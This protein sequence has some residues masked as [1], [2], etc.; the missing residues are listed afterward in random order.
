M[1]GELPRPLSATHPDDQIPFAFYEAFNARDFD[2]IAAMYPDDI[3][4]V[5]RR[6]GLTTTTKGRD[7]MMEQLHVMTDLGMYQLPNVVLAARG[8]L[9]LLDV[10]WSNR[11]DDAPIEVPTLLLIEYTL[12]GKIQAVSVWEPGDVA[13][14]ISALEER[15]GELERSSAGT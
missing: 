1:S 10:T 5:D 14:A 8:T 11:D 12:G 15:H 3:E 6:P 9:K 7:A 4:F 2:T 13:A